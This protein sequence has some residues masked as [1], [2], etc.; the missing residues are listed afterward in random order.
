MTKS[1]FDIVAPLFVPANKTDL[2]GKAVA[3][4]ADAVIADLEDS[5]AA[6]QRMAARHKLS[7]YFKSHAGTRLV[8]R[9]NNAAE[10]L[11]K[12]LAL[13]ARHSVQITDIMLP[14]VVDTHTVAR[15]AMLKKPVWALIESPAGLHALQDIAATSCVTRLGLG[16]VDLAQE[17]GA[18]CNSFGGQAL[19][20]YARIQLVLFSTMF[21]LKPPLNSPYFDFKDSDGL[22]SE[23]EF[24]VGMGFGGMLCIHPSQVPFVQ[25]A[26][27]PTAEKIAWA[28]RVVA[29]AREHDGVFQINGEMIDTPVIARAERI[30]RAGDASD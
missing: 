7:E 8:L 29:T 25:Q 10:D 27:S 18:D 1:R 21:G 15:L 4:G 6:S 24:A 5:V 17:I 19:L 11:E 3:S 14:K 13:V 16:G 23:A 20:N 9:I 30:L 2:I 28:Q 22:R 12:D 26:F